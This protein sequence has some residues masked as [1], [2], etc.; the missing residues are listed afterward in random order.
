MLLVYCLLLLFT[1]Y[2][3]SVRNLTRAEH[4]MSPVWPLLSCVGVVG[5][6]LNTYVLHVFYT[7]RHSLVTS[8]NAM[9]G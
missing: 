5:T 1:R 9:I 2:N 8:V 4:K 6:T 3:Q 7:E